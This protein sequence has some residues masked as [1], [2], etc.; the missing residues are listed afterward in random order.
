M[1][2]ATRLCLIG[3]YIDALSREQQAMMCCIVSGLLRHRRHIG[4][5]FFNGSRFD[6]IA[7]VWS[8]SSWI[9]H[10]YPSTWEEN[11]DFFNHA[12]V[13]V[14]LMS[15]TFNRVRNKYPCWTFSVHALWWFSFIFCFS[16][17][18]RCFGL[19]ASFGSTSKHAESPLELNLKNWK[20][21]NYT[22]TLDKKK[23]LGII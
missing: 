3:R 22:N 1:M 4:L 6:F 20:R 17:I 16:C 12:F 14:S 13:C 2:L 21:A 8:S 11:V 23:A 5:M 10:I 7:L 19:P 9:A 18:P 15:F